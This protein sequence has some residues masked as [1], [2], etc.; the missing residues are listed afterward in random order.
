[1]VGQMVG[2][3]SV[4]TDVWMGNPR[5]FASELIRKGKDRQVRREGGTGREG[6]GQAF[7]EAK[8][9]SFAGVYASYM[10]THSFC[11]PLLLL[12]LFLLF[13]RWTL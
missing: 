7:G 10:K 1:M 9:G 12:L 13:I 6:Q 2:A 3:K 11:L 8:T 5:S 4:E